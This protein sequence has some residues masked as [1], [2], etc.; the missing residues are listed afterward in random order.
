MSKIQD[1]DYIEEETNKIS[2]PLVAL[3][4]IV[5]FPGVQ[6]NIEIVRPISLKAFTAAAT[7]H[8]AKVI[9]AT[10]RDISLEE[11]T[12]DDFYDVG[13]VAEI[14]HVVKN[15]QG[16]LS[17]VFE[18]LSR[19]RISDIKATSGFYLAE[20]TLKEE[21][22]PVRLTKELEALM[23]E[24]KNRLKP[25]KDIHP[26]FTDDLRMNAE[27]IVNPGY[28]ADFVASSAVIDYKNKQAV[29]EAIFPKTRLEKLLVCL[30]EEMMLLECE[31]DIQQQVRQKIDRNQK[32]YFLREQIKAIQSE[33]GEDEDDEI[34]EYEA[35]ILKANLPDDIKEKLFKEL[36]KLSKTPFG[37]AEGTVIRAYLDTC[38]DFPFGI[39][40]SDEVDV[41]EAR[42]VLDA[43]HDGLEKVKERILEFVA[44]KQ[45]SKDVKSQIICLVGPPGVGKTSVA[46][47]IARALKRKICACIPWRYAR[48]GRNS[49]T[50][51][52]LRRRYARQNSQ[53]YN[54]R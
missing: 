37:A 33:L 22:A 18:G 29:L 12:E 11:P 1:K 21:K 14:K 31:H 34:S 6:L 44:I 3:R 27:A 17:V 20:G 15:P 38:L 43:D 10:Q 30:E 46:A 53:C 52:N 8:D 28:L 50:Q 26:S 35:K 32:D 4:G 23:Q 41:E 54:Q 7:V 36:N 45:F 25:L 24:T 47:S 42:M 40:S 48:R 16:N 13:V 51:K 39:V 49:R 19:I 5:G 2:L 9:L